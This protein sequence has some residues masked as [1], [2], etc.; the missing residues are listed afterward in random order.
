MM[1]KAELQQ[2]ITCMYARRNFKASILLITFH[3]AW[4][5]KRTRSFTTKLAIQNYTNRINTIGKPFRT[6]TVKN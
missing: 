4:N 1:R 3:F 6:L 2:E 5:V